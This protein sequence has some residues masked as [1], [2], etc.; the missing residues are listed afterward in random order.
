MYYLCILMLSF[1]THIMVFKSIYVKLYVQTGP[2]CR[3]GRINGN[4]RILKCR[5]CT[6][7]QAIFSREI[8]WSLDLKHRARIYGIRTYNQSDPV[9]W[10]LI[11][12]FPMAIFPEATSNFPKWQWINL[13]CVHIYVYIYIYIYTLQ[14]DRYKYLCSGWT[15]ALR[16]SKFL[17]PSHWGHLL[18]DFGAARAPQ[19]RRQ[20]PRVARLG[21]PEIWRQCR[22]TPWTPASLGQWTMV[23]MAYQC[24]SYGA[25][26]RWNV[27]S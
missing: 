15:I 16:G 11:V 21:A 4:F 17:W 25:M 20:L 18:S 26:G 9:A 19:E 8:P 3:N 23:D 10:P 1:E 2:I 7:F 14:T 5:Y 27:E 12:S 24:I 22:S 6:I 13:I